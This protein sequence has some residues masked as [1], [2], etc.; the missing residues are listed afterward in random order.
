MEL[1][2]ASFAMI[3]VSML[4]LIAIQHMRDDVLPT[5]C[6]PEGCRRCRK[7][8]P[9]RATPDAQADGGKV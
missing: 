9:K 2:L 7:D 3:F 6:T 4:I 1:L 5:G 8:C